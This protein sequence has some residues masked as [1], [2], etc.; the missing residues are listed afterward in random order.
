MTVDGPA[1]AGDDRPLVAEEEVLPDGRRITFY[2][3]AAAGP[4][5]ARDGA[6]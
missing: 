5:P 1:P 2:R 3:F 4:E 6:G